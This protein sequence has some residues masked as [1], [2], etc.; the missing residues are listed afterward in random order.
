M[1]INEIV[2][3]E[4][5]LK[6]RKSLLKKEKEF[7]KLRD[8]INQ[9]RRDLPWVKVEKEYK[10]DTG[11]GAESLAELFGDKSQLIVY[12]FMFDP[13][14]EEG[15][16]SCSFIADHYNASIVHLE[17]R[18]VSMV[19]ISKA[20]IDKLH[21]FKKR[22]GWNFKWV[23]SAKNNFNYDFHVSFTKEEQEKKKGYYNYSEQ[24]FLVPEA[25]GLSVFY[26]DD[27][28]DIFHTYSCFA[29]GLDTYIG[30]YHLLD[31]VPKGRDEEGLTYSMEWVRHNDKY[32]DESV[33]D[34]YVE[35]IKGSKN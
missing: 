20:S 6:E 25:P 2:S 29:R 16:K 10:F 21:S 13:Q 28:G 18:D 33:K 14:W 32:G 35:L 11:N 3:K 12:H 9:K 22:M 7:T 1:K 15:C 8:E 17:N 31:I 24:G 5:W 27:K 26:K 4:K 23:S 34:M 19:T 30:A